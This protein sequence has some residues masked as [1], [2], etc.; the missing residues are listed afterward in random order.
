MMHHSSGD[1]SRARV[2]LLTSSSGRSIIFDDASVHRTD[3]SALHTEGVWADASSKIIDHP[4]GDASKM[5]G[6][7]GARRV[8]HQPTHLRCEG[9]IDHTLGDASGSSK[10][11]TVNTSQTEGL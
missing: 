1:R 4:K 11:L 7:Y 9:L 5:H 6:N 2:P 8:M 10:H 3:R